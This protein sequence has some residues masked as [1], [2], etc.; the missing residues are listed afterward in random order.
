MVMRLLILLALVLGSAVPGLAVPIV[1]PSS[2]STYSA[3]VTNDINGFYFNPTHSVNE[4]FTLVGLSSVNTASFNFSM[5]ASGATGL[6]VNFDALINS[7]VV[8]KFAAIITPG[9]QNFNLNFNFAAIAAQPGSIYN[10]RFQ[11]TNTIPTGSGSV[12]FT[13]FGSGDLSSSAA[14]ELA[15]SA[16]TLPLVFMTVLLMALRSRRSCPV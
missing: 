4:N 3:G 13:G 16:G 11:V 6:P 15:A 9:V 12:R 10:V 7:V 2:T 1:F 14:P 5:G 8:G